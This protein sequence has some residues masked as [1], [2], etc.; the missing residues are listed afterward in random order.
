MN[1]VGTP[2]TSQFQVIVKRK[3]PPFW[4]DCHQ[5][6]SQFGYCWQCTD[7]PRVQYTNS[8]RIVDNTLYSSIGKAERFT[9]LVDA[10]PKPT[11]SILFNNLVVN[12]DSLLSTD[13]DTRVRVDSLTFSI[14]SHVLI[15]ILFFLR[16][17]GQHQVTYNFKTSNDT[18]GT[19][20]C[21][22]DNEMGHSSQMLHLTSS[23]SNISVSDSVYQ[24]YSD[25][26]V[27]EWSCASGSTLT[28]IHIEVSSSTQQPPG[29]HRYLIFVLRLLA[30]QKRHTRTESN[31]EDRRG[32]VV[33]QQ[34]RLVQGL[35]WTYQAH[36]QH[37]L[38]VQNTC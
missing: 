5:Q 20:E 14:R 38:S 33:S 15:I 37:N 6:M 19:Y 8:T 21:I 28:D 25:G 3:L 17:H 30:V 2:V 31:S 34:R 7:K 22:A 32:R 29:R 36:S 4:I 9:C 11:I 23:I 27:F 18:I 16:L 13:M 12:A 35:L 10:Y 24:V 1:G 26:Y